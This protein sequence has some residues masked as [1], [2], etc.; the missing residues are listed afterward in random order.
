M[1][2]TTRFRVPIV[3]FTII[4]YLSQGAALFVFLS[5]A[6]GPVHMLRLR[7]ALVVQ[8]IF[9]HGTYKHCNVVARLLDKS[10]EY[11]R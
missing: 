10:F 7:M 1:I 5:G 3:T 4:L 11:R 2:H 9:R 6:L 8:L